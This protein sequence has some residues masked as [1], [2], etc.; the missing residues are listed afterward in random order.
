MSAQEY[1]FAERSGTLV[2][3]LMLGGASALALSLAL[4]SSANAASSIAKA[5]RGGDFNQVRELIAD[6]AAVNEPEADGSTALLWAAYQSDPAMIS[7]LIEAGADVNK[8]NGLGIT[9]LL[10]AARTGDTPVIRAL[11]DGG[12]NIES[13]VRDGETPLMAAARVGRVDAV[14]LLLERGSD[15]NA[16]ESYQG[17]S[18]LMWAAAEGHGEVVGLLLDAGADP[19]LQAHVSELTERSVRTDFPTGGFTAAMW[20]AREGYADILSRLAASGADLNLKNGDNASALMIAIVNDRFD[21]AASMV[22]MGAEANDGAL[23]RAVE[24]RDATTDWRAKDGSRLRVDYPNEINALGLIRVLLEAGADPNKPFSGQ[25]HSASMCC[26]TTASGTPFYRAAVAADVDALKLLVE[27]GGDVEWMPEPAE[28]AAPGAMGPQGNRGKTPLMAA[29]DGG[30]GVGMAGGP[31]DI[32]ENSE[33][34]FRE[35]A[36]REPVDAMAVLLEAGADPN[37]PMA[38]DST[39]LHDAARGRKVELI[40]LLAEHGAKLD[41][42]NKEGLTALDLAEGR[43]GEG[44][45]GPGGGRGFAG[46]GPPGGDA[47]GPT[48]ED[49]AALLRELMEAQGVAIVEH[50]TVPAATGPGA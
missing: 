45:G 20:A 26:D 15:P 21:L 30:K 35:I 16:I 36:N 46:F 9:P 29:M 27:Y 34:P 11:L 23:F 49:V 50:G 7:M 31:G 42:L 3:R 5:A 24:M 33:V 40:Q 17:Q 39:L 43:R 10:Q 1:P 37:R 2:R 13:A 32:R 48:N 38:N 44:G 8:A 25:N 4:V 6:G 41:A 19:D 22:G 28:D 14:Q 18:A 12:A 47:E